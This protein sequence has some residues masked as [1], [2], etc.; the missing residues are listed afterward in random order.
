MKRI[1]YI[2]ILVFMAF[3]VNVMANGT[4]GYLS[5]Q[6]GIYD[7]DYPHSPKPQSPVAIPQIQQI[8]N[9][10]NLERGCSNCLFELFADENDEEVVFSVFITS[11][12]NIIVLPENLQGDYNIKLTRA[13]IYFYGN[14]FL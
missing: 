9:C 12:M 4:G 10:L 11:N 1:F 6:I 3:N 13:N 7:P 5:L 2:T 14:I 8:G